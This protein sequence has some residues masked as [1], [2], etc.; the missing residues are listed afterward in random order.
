[1]NKTLLL[2]LC[3][4]L[5]LNLLALTRWEQAEPAPPAEVAAATSTTPGAGAATADDDIVSVMRLSLED[6]QARRDALARELEQTQSSLQETQLTLEERQQNLERLRQEREQ[7]AGNLDQT[8][9]QAEQLSQ[10][11]TSA[12]TDATA[13]A[14]R[15]AQLQRELE[16]REAEAR[17]RA[18]ALAQLEQRQAEA[19]KQIESL[20]VAVRVAEQEKTMLR[21][22][23]TTLRQQVEAERQERIKVQ[24]TAVQLAQ[25]VGQL[26]EQSTALTQEIRENRPINANTLFNDF[27]A[28]RVRTV[29]QASRPAFFGTTDTRN[30][31]PRTV[32]V[33]DGVATYAVLHLEDTPFSYRDPSQADW[34]SFTI[35]Y[36]KGGRQ[37]P[38]PNLTFL[39]LD[40]RIVGLP[41]TPEQLKELGVK[42]Y[43]TTLDPFRFPEAVLI[44]R[45]G[46][47]YGEIPFK[48]D[49]ATPGYV[50]M[51]NR[52]MR[53]LFGDFSPSRGDLV[54]SKTGELL[55]IMVNS[56]YCAI[57]D[58]FA[59]VA[60]INTG[61]DLSARPTSP[62]LSTQA[63]RF[64]R[65]PH[66][67]R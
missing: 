14:E 65:L 37:L 52:L 33:T 25:G 24:E 29:L 9:A 43:Q 67:L 41:V 53:R 4:F 36:E 38:V 60:M 13:T 27:L 34:Q 59:P 56:D 28:N 42:V 22:A 19:Q 23:T 45:G 50:R 61:T 66:S 1:M 12:R 3:D 7:L 49:P 47:G 57:I 16:T 51:D 20:N 48:L 30:R 26:A 15:A 10:Q 32:F 54:L 21:E 17:R 40:P 11:L 62:V 18:E 31:D 55:G 8:R 58:A 35:A 2:I 64:N 63:A 44:T 5:L 39:R 46:T 6:E